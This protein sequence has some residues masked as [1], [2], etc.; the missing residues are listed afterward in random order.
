M[1]LRHVVKPPGGTGIRAIDRL[2]LS[3][4]PAKGGRTGTTLAPEARLRTLDAAI[5]SVAPK[6]VP[7]RGGTAGAKSGLRSG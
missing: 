1:G 4:T 3:P 7:V 6:A 5:E 2:V